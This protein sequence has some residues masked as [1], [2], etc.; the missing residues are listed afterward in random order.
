[1]NSKETAC[2]GMAGAGGLPHWKD[3]DTMSLEFRKPLGC[4]LGVRCLWPW[5][6]NLYGWVEGVAG[7][8][9][10]I[11]TPRLDFR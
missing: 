6:N 7:G 3:K 8:K 4:P 2:S 11:D 9:K 1:M 5:S 10:Q